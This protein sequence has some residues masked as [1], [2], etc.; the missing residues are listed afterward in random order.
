MANTDHADIDLDMTNAREPAPPS[1][2]KENRRLVFTGFW[3]VLGLL[4][5]V[6]A[7]VFLAISHHTHTTALTPGQPQKPAAIVLG[8]AVPS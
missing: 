7:L 5:V 3:L 2:T 6:L 1:E 8:H 4:V